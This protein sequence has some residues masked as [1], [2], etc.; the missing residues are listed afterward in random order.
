MK[1]M[2]LILIYWACCLLMSCGAL[3]TSEEFFNTIS[4]KD[5]P[6]VSVKSISYR[7]GYVDSE[8][9]KCGIISEPLFDYSIK[10]DT[11]S[12]YEV[13]VIGYVVFG[14][15]NYQEN[16]YEGIDSVG[17]TR[18]IV[19]S[20][21]SQRKLYGKNGDEIRNNILWKECPLP[22]IILK[23]IKKDFLIRMKY[24]RFLF[25]KSV[26]NDEMQIKGYT[27]QYRYCLY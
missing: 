11:L 21:H 25:N 15:K 2:K 5:I 14:K 1:K 7:T 6:D 20:L 13:I 27:T 23:K 17:I 19:S 24:K 10:Y 18:L 16:Q 8:C 12:H 4:T 22:K 26:F 3:L 9:I